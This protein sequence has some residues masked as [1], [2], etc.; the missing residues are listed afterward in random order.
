MPTPPHQRFDN[1]LN[2]LHREH[3]RSW[4]DYST[5]CPKARARYAISKIDKILERDIATHTAI[6]RAQNELSDILAYV[7]FSLENFFQK[8][9][10]MAAHRTSTHP[11][12][13]S[14]S[15]RG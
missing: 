5:I 1:R 3:R 9:R 15:D 4:T 12:I 6:F 11:D 14:A 2:K 10:L 13:G 8:R 7:V